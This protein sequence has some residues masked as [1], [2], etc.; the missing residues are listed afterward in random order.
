MQR[1]AR[2]EEIPGAVLFLASDASSMVTGNLI[3]TDG[4]FLVA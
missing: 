2:P 3:A 1:G 4:G